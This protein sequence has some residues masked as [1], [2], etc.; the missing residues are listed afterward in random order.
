[1][2]K[3]KKRSREHSS[4]EESGRSIRKRLDRMEK[5]IIDI[6]GKEKVIIVLFFLVAGLQPVNRLS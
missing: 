6:Y 3:G 4:D 2:G 1:M 5:I